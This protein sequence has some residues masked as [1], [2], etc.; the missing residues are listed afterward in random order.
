MT[1]SD[2]PQLPPSPGWYPDPWGPAGRWRWWTGRD[3]T[4]ATS[5]AGSAAAAAARR[6]RLPAWLSVP[7][8]LGAV[9]MVPVLLLTAV[10]A[11]LAVPL[12]L[13]PAVIVCPVLIW[14]D[15]VEPEPWASRIHALLWGGLAAG[16]LAVVVNTLVAVVAGEAVSAV[17]SAPLV[18]EGMKVAAIL[19]AVRRHEVDGVM[20]GV[21]Y[22]AWA[23]IGFA[24]IEDLIYFAD[25]LAQGFLVPVFIVRAIL[26]P[27]AHPLFTA[28]AGLA[29]GAAIRRG[30]PIAPAAL[31]GYVL[32]VL[33]HALWNG[34][35]TAAPSMGGGL[36]LLLAAVIFVS[37]FFGV[38]ITLVRLRRR[39]ERRFVDLV[40]WLSERY[41]V[42]A[43][44]AM[45][46]GRI[47][48]VRRARA[49]LAPADRRRF[50]AVHAALARLA[51]LHDRPG[52]ADPLV[53]GRL[54]DQLRRARASG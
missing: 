38:A 34:S 41:G 50:D 46:F 1:T 4:P 14:L 7:I 24:V 8:L 51:L 31:G 23:G 18:E 27:F 47:R 21:I 16:G 29:I 15:R 40:P 36:F 45:A 22:A 32:A 39:E 25:A 28:C 49:G 3:W 11:P 53:E 35:L 26:S 17:A 44:E 19:W 5:P 33:A 12:A 2:V 13:I 20:D 42:P 43:A 6:P 10:G 30:R 9:V 52:G 37:L 54:V 48:D